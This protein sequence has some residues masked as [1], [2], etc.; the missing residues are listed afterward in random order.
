[1]MSLIYKVFAV[2]LWF[3]VAILI[4]TKIGIRRKDQSNCDILRRCSLNQITQEYTNAFNFN[5]Q[6]KLWIGWE[7]KCRLA[8]EEGVSTSTMF[9]DLH[10]LS[11][12]LH[13]TAQ[14]FVLWCLGGEEVRGRPLV[15]K[16]KHSDL[17]LETRDKGVLWALWVIFSVV[18][19]LNLLCV[20]GL[21]TSRENMRERSFSHSSQSSLS[22]YNIY[23]FLG[24]WHYCLTFT[25]NSKWT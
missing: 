2:N 24:G 21:T 9:A 12:H 6:L 18:K 19:T 1:M 11:T 17:S 10:L 15:V 8:Q 14:I 3:R 5:K 20:T 16:F 4:L 13:H 7:W 23:W 22:V 25:I